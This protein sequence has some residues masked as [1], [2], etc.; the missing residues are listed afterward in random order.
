MDDS[1]IRAMAKW[2][3]VPAVYGWLGLDRRGRWRLRGEAITHSGALAFIGR[4]YGCDEA[5][6][7]YLQ[8]GP[9]RVF[10]SLEYTPWVFFSQPGGSLSTH[11][12]RSVDR[13][14]AAWIDEEGALLLSTEHGPGLFCD[15]DLADALELFKTPDG[16]LLSETDLEQALAASS[17]GASGCVGI[18]WRSDVIPVGH[19]R[20]SD[21]PSRLGFKANPVEPAS[22]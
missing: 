10:V 9:Q 6:A 4:N 11:T 22:S 7:W 16:K 15:R 14:L 17:A 21:V 8:N 18:A 5:G 20:R 3:N 12:G 19:M 2:P 13:V 1:V